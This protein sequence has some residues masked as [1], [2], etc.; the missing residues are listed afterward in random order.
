MEPASQISSLAEPALPLQ[1]T[2]KYLRLIVALLMSATVFEGY[3]ITIFHLCTPNIA[4]TFGLSDAAI[5]TIATIV[6]FGGVFSFVLVTG[7]D[8]YGRKPILSIT[9]VFYT[10][11]TLMTAL[12]RG[13]VTFAI[14][15][16]SAQLFLAAEF[17]VAVTMISEEFP[18]EARGRAIAALHT[19]AFVG[20]AAAGLLYGRV[21]PSAWGWRGMYLLGIVPLILTAFLRRGLRETMR[22]QALEATRIRTGIARDSLRRKLRI[23]FSEFAGPY[24]GRL[25]LVAMLWNSLGLVGGPTITFFSLLATR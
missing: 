1:P 13:M 6:R 17:G 7:A 23:A 10:L 8:L 2:T 5:G 16:S 3:D 19:V 14:F 15:Q 20:V 22:F 12:S 21:A 9:V 4:S 18:D 11:F 25:V 24:R